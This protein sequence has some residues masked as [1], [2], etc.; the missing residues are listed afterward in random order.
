[1]VGGVAMSRGPTIRRLVPSL[2]ETQN[3]LVTYVK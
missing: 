2:D 3:T 1:M